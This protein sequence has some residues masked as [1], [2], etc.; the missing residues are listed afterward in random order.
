MLI[1]DFVGCHWLK[2]SILR[3]KSMSISVSETTGDVSLI[4]SAASEENISYRPK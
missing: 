4:I 2:H 1:I 3:L